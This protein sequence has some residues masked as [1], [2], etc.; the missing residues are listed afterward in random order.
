MKTKDKVLEILQKNINQSV[1]GEFLAAECEVSRAAI[2]KAVNSLRQTGYNIQGTTNGGYLL[3]QNNDLFSKELFNEFLCKNYPQYSQNHIECFEQIDSTNT[4]A[5]M[6]LSKSGSLRNINGELTKEG[7]ILNNSIY[8]AEYQTNGRGRLGRTFVSPSKTGI[9]QSVIVAPQGGIAQPSVLTAS[10]AVAVCRV[11]K[12]LYNIDAKIKWIN[13]IFYEGK[14]LCGI[15]TEG[16]ANFESNNIESAV[17]GI[18]INVK[19]NPDLPPEIK[20]IATSIS[21]TT[22]QNQI[23]RCE[24]SANICGETLSIFNEDINKVMQE[25]KN[26]SFIIGKE[27]LVHP[28]I[29]QNEK[30]YKATVV[31]INEKA[32]LVVKKDDGTTVCLSSGEVS[33]HSKQF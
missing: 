33:L 7:E 30:D 5:K 21:E 14:K 1:S 29:N 26:L 17:I 10:T 12:R 19:E 27:I 4:Y 20:E 31:D 28:V 13:D 15:L 32:E 23:N 2:W 3:D 24:L 9:Y 6:L 22:T 25:Y 11:L 8:V 16:F 18:G